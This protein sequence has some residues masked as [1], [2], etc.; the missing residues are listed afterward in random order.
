MSNTAD[1]SLDPRV[2]RMN[3]ENDEYATNAKNHWL[4]WQVFHLK[5]RGSQPSHVGIVHAPE[6]ELAMVLAKEQYGRRM[7]TANLWV[8][9][10]ADVYSLD[11]DDEDMFS[12]ATSDEKL[13]REATGFSVRDKIEAYKAKKEK[14]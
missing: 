5:K 14:A 4:T 6:P 11:A 3:F 10:T 1:K 8:V 13:Y 7:K 9:R 12:T 2:K